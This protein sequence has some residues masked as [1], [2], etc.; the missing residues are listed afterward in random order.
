[1][2]ATAW[3]HKVCL[4]DVSNKISYFLRADCS[5]SKLHDPRRQYSSFLCGYLSLVKADGGSIA[6]VLACAVQPRLQ[7]GIY[8]VLVSRFAGDVRS[9]G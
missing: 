8:A 7:V 1:M 2:S 5:L 9:A 4:V 3:Q 6:V